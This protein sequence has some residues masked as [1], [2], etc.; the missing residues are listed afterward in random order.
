MDDRQ[1][2]IDEINDYTDA[3]SDLGPMY[4]NRQG[5]PISLGEWCVDMED[6]SMRRVA[7]DFVGPY[8][9]STVWLGIDHSFGSGGPPLIFETAVFHI[10]S[11]MDRE[12]HRYATELE[13]K[14]GHAGVVD[15]LKALVD[16]N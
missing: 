14:A 12:M 6:Q 2:R 1:K 10:G 4:Y 15:R 9:V 8:R 11:L 5:E 3:L 16:T 13:A 7:E